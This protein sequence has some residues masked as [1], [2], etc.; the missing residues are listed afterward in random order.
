MTLVISAP[1]FVVGRWR[2]SRNEE[3][4]LPAGGAGDGGGASASPGDEGF[5]TSTKG[6][7]GVYVFVYVCMYLCMCVCVYVFVNVCMYLCIGVC[8]RVCVFVFVYVCTYSCMCVLI[9]IHL[10]IS[11]MYV[12]VS[13]LKKHLDH[14]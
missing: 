13:L 4:P 11:C 10:Y 9:H 5:P 7:K 8:V 14:I 3:G 1:L 2:P 12:P 6:T